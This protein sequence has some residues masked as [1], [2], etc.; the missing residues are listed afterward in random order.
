MGNPPKIW[1]SRTYQ[2]HSSSLLW[3]NFWRMKLLLKFDTIR[4]K[5]LHDHH[6]TDLEISSIMIDGFSPR[7]APCLELGFL[8]TPQVKNLYKITF[9]NMLGEWLANFTDPGSILLSLLYAVEY[10][11]FMPYLDLRHPYL[12]RDKYPRACLS[13]FP[14]HVFMT[15]LWPV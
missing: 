3:P 9:T 12:N 7:E 14:C 1:V 8:S 11:V 15:M 10:W 6:R 13:I 4:N 2:F 5:L